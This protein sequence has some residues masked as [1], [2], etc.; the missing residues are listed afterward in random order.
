VSVWLA[1]AIAALIGV[2]SG[3]INSIL[4]WMAHR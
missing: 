3:I 2:A 4:I 1:F